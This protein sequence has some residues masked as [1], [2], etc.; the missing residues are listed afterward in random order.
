[1]GAIAKC[2]MLKLDPTKNRP[3]P[4]EEHIKEAILE[5]FDTFLIDNMTRKVFD[6]VWIELLRKKVRIL[7]SNRC[8]RFSIT[9]RSQ[10]WLHLGVPK[11]Q[12][13]TQEDIEA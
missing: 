6:R 3:F 10:L 2:L 7:I 5:A 8:G 1:M 4:R 12:Q 9:A 13:G 11:P